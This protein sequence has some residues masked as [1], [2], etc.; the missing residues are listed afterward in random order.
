M[1]ENGNVDCDGGSD[2]VM[3]SRIKPGRQQSGG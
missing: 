1:A 2:G 3:P